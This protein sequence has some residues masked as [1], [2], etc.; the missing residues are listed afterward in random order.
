[1]GVVTYEY[2]VVS[3]ISPSRLFKSFILDS[4]NLIPKVVP[5]AFKSFE[6]LEGDG[7]VG[8]IKLIT[9]GEGS[10]FKFAKHKVEEIDEAN[11]T[12]KYSVIEGDALGDEIES[13]S[14][15]VKVDA[16]P[17]GGS[18]VKTTSSYHTKT[19]H[20]SITVEKIKEG[21]EKAKAIFHA[22][23]AHLHAHPHEY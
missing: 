23:E 10:Q 4:D 12:Y 1:M 17:D 22:I 21:K 19:E 5:G 7:G 13:I 8:T 11:C 3:T 20:H 15:V 2:E 6:I 16:G 18:V 14:Y 9:F